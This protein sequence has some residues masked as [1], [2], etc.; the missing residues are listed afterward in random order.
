MHDKAMQYKQILRHQYIFHVKD[1]TD[2][3]YRNK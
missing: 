2:Q 3:S 1:K